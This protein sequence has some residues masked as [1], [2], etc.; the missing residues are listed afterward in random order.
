VTPVYNFISK[1]QYTSVGLMAPSAS[2]KVMLHKNNKKTFIKTVS[3][4]KPGKPTL[5]SKAQAPSTTR[6]ASSRAPT[7]EVVDDEDDNDII[8]E[9]RDNSPS[10][11]EEEGDE[12]EL[13]MSELSKLMAC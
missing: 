6:P 1:F 8:M 5:S 9:E 11:S 4:P 3:K 7:I 12:S 10:E 13:S 2:K